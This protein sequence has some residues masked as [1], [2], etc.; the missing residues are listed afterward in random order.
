MPE[1]V[2]PHHQ[3]QASAARQ[4]AEGLDQGPI[5]QAEIRSIL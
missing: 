1:A 2:D 4:Q 3:R 5:R